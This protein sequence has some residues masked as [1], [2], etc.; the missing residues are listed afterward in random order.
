MSLADSWLLY[1]KV[2][3]SSKNPAEESSHS[4]LICWDGSWEQPQGGTG[5]RMESLVCLEWGTKSGCSIPDGAVPVFSPAFLISSILPG[6]ESQSDSFTGTLQTAHTG[7]GY[8]LGHACY[9]V[10]DQYSMKQ[11]RKFYSKCRTM[12]GT[13]VM[14]PEVTYTVF[15]YI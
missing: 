6:P 5:M 8:G 11:G 2:I 14:V 15:C 1:E 9:E 3:T 10:W 13:S 7:F 4:E 12:N